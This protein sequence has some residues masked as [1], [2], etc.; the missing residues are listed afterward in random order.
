MKNLFRFLMAVAV[1]FTASCA[2][3]DISSSIAGGEVEVSFTANLADL[4]TRADEYGSGAHANTLK[5]FVYQYTDETSV[6]TYLENVLVYTGDQG[7]NVITKNG[8]NKFN[9]SLT[10]VKG[11]KYNILFWADKGDGS[12]YEVTPATGVVTANYEGILANEESLDAFFGSL[13]N[14]DPAIAEDQQRAKGITLQRPFAQLNAYTTDLTEVGQ[15]GVELE[16][17]AIS[18]S[19]ATS[20]N[21][22]SEEL[23]GSEET[24]EFQLAN[25]PTDGAGHISMNYIFAPAT[26]ND[27]ADVTFSY[28]EKDEKITFSPAT[29]TNIPLKR[30]YRTNIKGA[31]LTKSTD[32]E[33]TIDPLFDEPAEEVDV[34]DGV[35][36]TEPEIVV[37]NET[38]ETAYVVN[39]GS[40][41]AWLAALLNGTL[42]ASTSSTRATTDFNIVLTED[43]ELGGNEWT[44][45]GTT[46]N[47]FKGTFDGGNFTVSNFTV[48]QQEGHAGLF[49]YVRSTTIKNLKVENVEIAA[50][51]YAGA[52]VGQGYCRIEN[53]HVNNVN[54]TLTTKNNDL[55][56]KA[57]GIIGQNCEGTLYVKNSTA[58]NVT[59]KGY[60]DLGGIAG[61]AHDNNIV[62]GCSA[63]N[64]SLVQDLSVNYQPTTP[65]TLGGVV[66]RFGNNVTYENNTESEIFI[67]DVERVNDGNG[68]YVG[69]GSIITVGGAKAVVFS[70]EDCI[71]AV[72]VEELNLKG[73]NHADAVTWASNLGNGWA[74]ASIYDLD[75]IHAVRANL[76]AALAADNAENALFC[77]TD[78][79]EEG[80]YAMYLS[81]TEAVGNDP[82]GQ[83]YFSNRV[84]LKYF[85]LN[86]YWDY[87]YSTF[88][89]IS[90]SAPLKDNYFARG[91]YTFHKVGS[92]VECAG[93]KAVVYEVTNDAYKAVSVAQGGE[94]T[95]NEAMAWAEGLG[96]GWSLASLDEL[97]AIYKV[98]TD[99]NKV[100]AADSAENVLFEEDNKE[101]DGT[102]AAYWSS[103]LVESASTSTKAYYFYFDSKGRET[104]SFTMFPVEYSRAVYTIAK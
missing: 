30:N 5:F 7:S 76:N 11:M 41:L 29:Y 17:S 13:K 104:T 66:G 21:L 50:N 57:G 82:Q 37:N 58:N 72:S 60:R 35:S 103:T 14:F 9:F 26:Q 25:I 36:V 101:E 8:G 48:K 19:V 47:P 45:I 71:K 2:K 24:V 43:I 70:I 100:L 75:A 49:G 80:K 55:G 44:P 53:C 20:L 91:V 12:I 96:N 77:E 59:I 56:D 99:L 98:R 78:Y 40:D 85:N 102:Y 64:I 27:L 31:L 90:K 18:A 63:N 34:W 61:M 62:S 94:M 10:L 74:L 81:S 52:I 93:Q 51:H 92:I 67:N 86:G 87:P 32:F 3:E 42:T 79:I 84:H 89:T 15:S 39:S 46:A 1:L 16:K 69:V 33:V 73:K 95:W 97:K 6:G 4:G 22:F 65:V 68:N 28:K 54:I 38:G 83:A 88:A 23:V